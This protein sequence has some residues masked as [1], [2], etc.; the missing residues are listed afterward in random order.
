VR[1]YKTSLAHFDIAAKYNSD[2]YSVFFSWGH[3]LSNL[4]RI[5][6]SAKEYAAAVEK[7]LPRRRD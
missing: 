2:Y 7:V 4:G 5:T 1:L 6:G 3:A